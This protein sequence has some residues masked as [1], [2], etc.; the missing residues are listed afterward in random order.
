M[1]PKQLA[2]LDFIRDRIALTGVSPTYEE[3]RQHLDF[4]SKSRL[5]QA[6][7]ALVADGHLIKAPERARGLSLP[8]VDLRSAPTPALRGELARRER[9]S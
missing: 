6:V 7:K 8:G 9:L 5:F 3:M 2:L 4:R 1:T